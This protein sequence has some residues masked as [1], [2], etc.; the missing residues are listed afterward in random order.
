MSVHG[1]T[2]ITAGDMVDIRFP[3]VGEDHDNEIIEKTTSGNYLISHLRHNFI[4][5]T[6]QHNITLRAVKDGKGG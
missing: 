2:G 1:H 3:I 6:S 4:L 5:A